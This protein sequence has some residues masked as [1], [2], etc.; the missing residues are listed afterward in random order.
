MLQAAD[1]VI[2][3][4]AA[5][6]VVIARVDIPEGTMLLREDVRTAVKVLA[7][8][9]IAVKDIATARPCAATTRSSASR[10]ARSKPAITCTSTTSRWGASSA[11]TRSART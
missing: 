9:K 10:R 5:D 4:N 11:T 6:D 7:G 1:I 3:L 8:H 2:R